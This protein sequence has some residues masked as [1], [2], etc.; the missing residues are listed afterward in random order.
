MAKSATSP[1]ACPLCGGK[2]SAGYTTFTADI[3]GS[4]VVVRNVKAEICSQCGEEWIDNKTAE[5]LEKIV[6]DARAKHSQ[7]EVLSM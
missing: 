5:H 7:V 1:G 6:Q 4:V 2:K 3:T